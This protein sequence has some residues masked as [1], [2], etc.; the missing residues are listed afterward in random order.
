VHCPIWPE[1]MRS[2]TPILALRADPAPGGPTT[3]RVP[4]RLDGGGL[5]S[6]DASIVSRKAFDHT[7]LAYIKSPF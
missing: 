7:K 2:R 5:R 1:G 6:A 3:H 4:V